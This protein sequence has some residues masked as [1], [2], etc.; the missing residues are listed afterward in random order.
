VTG[1]HRQRTAKMLG[2]SSRTLLRKI[3]KYGL[4]DPLQHTC[5]IGDTA[6][7]AMGT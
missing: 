6:L 5:A 3:R 1:G 7:D 4:E 2:I